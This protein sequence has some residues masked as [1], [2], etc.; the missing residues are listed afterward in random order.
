[1][2][3]AALVGGDGEPC[4]DAHAALALARHRRGDLAAA[5]TLFE[6]LTEGPSEH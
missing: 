3:P 1:M 2:T 4:G 6:R 5:I